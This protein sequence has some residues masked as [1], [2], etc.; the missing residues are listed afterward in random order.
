MH[1]FTYG[2]LMYP[3]IWTRVVAGRYRAM[4]GVI[5]EFERRRIVGES[6]PALIYGTG[7]VEGVVYCDVATP[8]LAALDRFELEGEDYRRIEVSVTLADGVELSASTYLYLRE[9]RIAPERWDPHRFETH[10]LPGFI[11]T[12]CRAHAPGRRC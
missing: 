10:D 4:K 12:Y 5:R 8:D 6:Y 9:E 2:S 11:A 1:L 7:T 3:A